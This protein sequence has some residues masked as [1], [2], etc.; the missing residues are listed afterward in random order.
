ML[1]KIEK[2]IER[3]L[4]NKISILTHTTLLIFIEEIMDTPCEKYIELIEQFLK[5]LHKLRID[6]INVK[7]KVY[8]SVFSEKLKEPS[9][10]VIAWVL[11]N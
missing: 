8:S 1:I 10:K 4:H 7:D 5:K 11:D 3:V 9:E 6:D 2:I